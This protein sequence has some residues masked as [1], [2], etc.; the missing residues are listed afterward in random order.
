MAGH[1]EAQRRTVSPRKQLIAP[2]KKA[3]EP[4]RPQ[5]TAT[6]DTIKTQAPVVPAADA[7]PADTTM[8]S[9]ISANGDTLTEA[10]NEAKLPVE[11]ADSMHSYKITIE[12]IYY[13]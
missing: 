9:G 1:A 3:P 12:D 5:A 13:L 4:A 7:A 8:H 2:K 10:A 11:K 6:K